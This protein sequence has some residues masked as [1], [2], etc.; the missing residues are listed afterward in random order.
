MPHA[1]DPWPSHVRIDFS[2]S[3][4]I[5][6]N[7]HMAK[8]SDTPQ[9]IGEMLRA[10]AGGIKLLFFENLHHF[11]ADIHAKVTVFIL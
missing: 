9:N 4:D 7:K 11:G 6:M 1:S 8:K 10:G 3:T 2:L 5:V